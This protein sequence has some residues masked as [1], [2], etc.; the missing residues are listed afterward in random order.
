MLD[1]VRPAPG[2]E[3]LRNFEWHFWDR[4][5]HAEKRVVPVTGFGALREDRPHGPKDIF[6]Y[7]RTLFALSEDGTRFAWWRQPLEG[8][9][10]RTSIHIVDTA[11]GK[12][13]TL[14]PVPDAMSMVPDHSK[15][16]MPNSFITWSGALLL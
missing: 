12:E 14:C 9:E 6:A 4:L 2:E 11:T 3:D 13:L 16:T 8:E 7:R 1:E 5:C 10:Q 15:P